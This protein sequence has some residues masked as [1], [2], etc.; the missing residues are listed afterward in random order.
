MSIQTSI[1]I[2]K[3]NATITSSSCHNN[4]GITPYPSNMQYPR[5]ISKHFDNYSRLTHPVSFE[6]HDIQSL[7]IRQ[8]LEKLFDRSEVFFP[9][10]HTTEVKQCLSQSGAI[11]VWFES[12]QLIRSPNECLATTSWDNYRL[13]GKWGPRSF[14]SAR[15]ALREAGEIAARQ[16]GSSLCCWISSSTSMT[17]FLSHHCSADGAHSGR[18]FVIWSGFFLQKGRLLTKNMYTTSLIEV[19]QSA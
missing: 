5:R 14:N 1:Y 2:F 11:H 19:P 8:V 6:S 16:I 10:I 4:L 13:Q 12:G 3:S 7:I 17:S 15:G 9:L 18:H